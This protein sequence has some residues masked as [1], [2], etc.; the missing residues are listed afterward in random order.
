MD[1]LDG[2]YFC[3]C[4]D[5]DPF[6]SSVGFQHGGLGPMAGQGGH[7]PWTRYYCFYCLLMIMKPIIST[8]S[9]Q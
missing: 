6:S 3:C 4:H 2:I 7:Q 9:H 8:V 1:V 5:E